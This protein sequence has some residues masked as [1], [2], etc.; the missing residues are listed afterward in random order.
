M[1][2]LERTV[3]LGYLDADG[4]D[5]DDAFPETDEEL[6]FDRV[7]FDHPLWVV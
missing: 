3:T 1:P 2:S 6:E 4:G 7:P 5:W